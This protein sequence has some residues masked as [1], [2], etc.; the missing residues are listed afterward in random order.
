M[1]STHADEIYRDILRPREDIEKLN[2]DT[3][4]LMRKMKPSRN[5]DII[6][7]KDVMAEVM[8]LPYLEG[9]SHFNNVTLRMDM[10]EAFSV[11]E[12]KS[13]FVS[14]IYMTP[15]NLDTLR[16]CESNVDPQSPELWGAKIHV[17]D[18][19]DDNTIVIASE[20]HSR[21][22]VLSFADPLP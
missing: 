16:T 6:T 3:L 21:T 2:Q 19:V 14:H 15:H 17:T 7:T 10:I 12:R 22:V 9:I 5:I 20:N 4:A 13:L 8:T 18:L 11:L 1:I